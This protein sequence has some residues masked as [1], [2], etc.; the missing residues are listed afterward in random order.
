MS[1][2]TRK[3]SSEFE[4]DIKKIS[5][6]GSMQFRTKA[7]AVCVSGHGPRDTDDLNNP[8]DSGLGGRESSG[9]VPNLDHRNGQWSEGPRRCTLTSKGKACNFEPWYVMVCD[10]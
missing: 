10:G 2:K 5:L 8:G 1:K 6:V 3:T 4:I 7:G 9:T